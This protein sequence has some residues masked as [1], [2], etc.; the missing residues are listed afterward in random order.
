MNG[1]D[2]GHVKDVD[3]DVVV[4]RRFNELIFR[5]FGACRI[6]ANQ[7]DFTSTFGNFQRRLKKKSH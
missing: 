3:E 5:F 6:P 2:V 1:L 7:M 4:R